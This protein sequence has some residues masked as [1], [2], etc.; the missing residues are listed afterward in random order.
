VAPYEA[1]PA[2]KTHCRGNSDGGDITIK[3]LKE[4]TT[5]VNSNG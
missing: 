4:G 5:T 3:G 2:D 1:T